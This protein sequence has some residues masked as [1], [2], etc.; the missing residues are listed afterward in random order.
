M[1]QGVWRGPPRIQGLGHSDMAEAGSRE[2]LE[3]L[4]RATLRDALGLAVI[5]ELAAPGS[6]PRSEGKA[7]RV[8]DQRT[9]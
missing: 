1:A 5:V 6:I 2:V 7:V 8:L 3:A 4:A 9:G